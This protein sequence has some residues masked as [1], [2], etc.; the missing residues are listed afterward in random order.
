MM[1]KVNSMDDQNLS[2]VMAIFGATG[3]LTFK[4]LM[5]ALYNLEKSKL[6]PEQFAVVCI[7]R[8]DKTNAGYQ[9]DVYENIQKNIKQKIDEKVW[10]SFSKRVSY[11]RQD[12]TEDDGYPSLKKVLDQKGGNMLFYLSVSPHYFEPIIYKLKKYDLANSENGWRRVVI[13][14]P[15][16]SDLETAQILNDRLTKVFPEKDIYRIDHY[17]GK[18][19]LQNLLVLRFANSFFEPVWNAKYI[20]SIQISSCEKDGVGT[21]GAYYEKSG[22]LKDMIQNHLLQLLTLT[23]MEPPESFDERHIRKKKTAVLKKLAACRDEMKLVRGQYGA[24]KIDGENVAGYRQEER[25]DENSNVETFA[26][27]KLFIDNERWKGV[28]IYIRTGK[29]LKNTM[30]EV[31]IEFKNLPQTKFFSDSENI[32]PNL[33]VIKIQPE[34]GME[35][36]FNTKK[37]GSVN[38]IVPVKMNFCQNCQTGTNSPE[39][40]ERLLYDVIRGDATLFTRWEEVKY[41]WI[42][43]DNIQKLWQKQFVQFPNYEAGTSGPKE[44]EELLESDN[45]KWWCEGGEL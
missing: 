9:N 12:F 28:P 21:R 23:A 26:A 31:V 3:D 15:F 37:P 25:V 2:C 24:G 5:P 30:T 18:E 29:R 14:K 11:Q 40:Y 8:R 34:E 16:G 35:F 17:L 32:S 22:A 10:G 27:L 19:M 43:A 7:G 1:Q 39:A 44:A 4:K 13:E 38:T 6:L 45:R 41:S 20:D 33:L 36:K 42:F